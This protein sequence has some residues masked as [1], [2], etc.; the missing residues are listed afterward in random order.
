M[1]DKDQIELAERMWQENQKTQDICMQLG[2]SPRK[3]ESL[4]TTDLKTLET[5]RQGTNG[6]KWNRT[7]PPP[8][9]AEI[10]ERAAEVRATWDRET[11]LE[12]RFGY[13]GTLVEFDLSMQEKRSKTL[14]DTTQ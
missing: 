12:R 1:L 6:G 5:R 2:I 4:R 14:P 10:A 9:L 8:S 13:R 11:E 7:V 3:F